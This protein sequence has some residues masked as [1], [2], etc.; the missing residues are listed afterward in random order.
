[1]K[2]KKLFPGMASIAVTAFLFIGSNSLAQENW[3]AP[4]SA[5]EIVN[6]LKG[7]ANAAASGKKTYKMLCVVCHGAKG[8]GD[9]IGSAGL[10]PKPTDLTSTKVQAQTDGAI[11]WKIEEGRSPMPSYKTTL[12]E[13]KRWEIINYIRKLKK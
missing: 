10:Q 5:D 6:P 7:D 9:G 3:V 11:F 4:V 8:K 13:K 1:M 2:S 12:Q